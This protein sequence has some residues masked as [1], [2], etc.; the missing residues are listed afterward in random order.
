[1]GCAVQAAIAAETLD[2]KRLSSYQKLQNELA[3]LEQRQDQQAQLAAKQRWKQIHKQ[4]RNHPKLR[5]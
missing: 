3:Y 4:L 5:Q 1:P 2:P